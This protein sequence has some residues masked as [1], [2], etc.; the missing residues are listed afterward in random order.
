[1]PEEWK[2]MNLTAGQWVMVPIG[3]QGVDVKPV[4]HHTHYRVGDSGSP[5][6]LV[7]EERFGPVDEP[8]VKGDTPNESIQYKELI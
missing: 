3:P 5:L 1:M 7:H 2:V 4:T 6:P 8:W